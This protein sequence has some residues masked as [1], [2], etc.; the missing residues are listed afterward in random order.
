M[1]EISELVAGI[2]KIRLRQSRAIARAVDAQ[3]AGLVEGGEDAGY[4]FAVA[5]VAAAADRTP[6]EIEELSG[7]VLELGAAVTRIMALAGFSAVGEA[8]PPLEPASLPSGGS[9]KSGAPSPPAAASPRT[10][11]AA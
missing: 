7:S 4:A 1:S 3:R 11:S 2:D 6:Q 8:M 10:R 9:G 5:V